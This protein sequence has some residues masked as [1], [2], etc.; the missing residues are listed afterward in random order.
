MGINLKLLLVCVLSFG[1]LSAAGSSTDAAVAGAEEA[2][3]DAPIRPGVDRLREQARRNIPTREV[4]LAFPYFGSNPFNH[5]C[6][7][8]GNPPL[9]YNPESC[10]RGINCDFHMS[11][12][13]RPCN[14]A[15]GLGV[16]Y[17]F[18]LLK[19]V[20]EEKVREFGPEAANMTTERLDWLLSDAFQEIQKIHIRLPEVV[21]IPKDEQSISVSGLAGEKECF[22][23]RDDQLHVEGGVFRIAPGGYSFGV[24]GGILCQLIHGTQKNL[25][26]NILEEGKAF[27]LTIIKTDNNFIQ[28]IL[29]LNAFLKK[30]VEEATE[31]QAWIGNI[32]VMLNQLFKDMYLFGD[33]MY[34]EQMWAIIDYL[35]REEIREYLRDLRNLN[36][37][38]P[39]DWIGLEKEDGL[40][41]N[42]SYLPLREKGL[43]CVRLLLDWTRSAKKEGFRYEG[44]HPPRRFVEGVPGGLGERETPAIGSIGVCFA[45]ILQ[46][47]VD[48]K[49]R[50]TVA[51]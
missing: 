24:I 23:D 27:S 50:S 29:A 39:E 48:E 22:L 34:F 28:L 40:Y 44:F 35:D 25:P 36:P 45:K 33:E 31:A 5:T 37:E 14:R 32:P 20:Q 41:E 3:V 42:G 49:L 43:G 12:N 16:L 30:P 21:P 51:V 7:S 10:D 19:E 17:K 46:E 6:Y 9:L 2:V 8:A 1:Y 18:D 26:S 4:D 13:G 47:F 38:M 11:I 15:D